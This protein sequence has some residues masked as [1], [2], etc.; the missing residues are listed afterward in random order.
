MLWQPPIPLHYT[1]ID[2]AQSFN[3][4]LVGTNPLLFHQYKSINEYEIGVINIIRKL[5]SETANN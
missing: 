4:V 3:D 2:L 1:I 5:R